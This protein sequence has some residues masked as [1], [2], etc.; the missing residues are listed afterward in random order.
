MPTTQF[1]I[2]AVPR[3]VYEPLLELS[4]LELTHYHTRWI[5]AEADLEFSCRVSLQDAMAGC[6]N[7]AV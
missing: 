3:Q 5:V 1:R 7:C 6:F 4:D 2:Q